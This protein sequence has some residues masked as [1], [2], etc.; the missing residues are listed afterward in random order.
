[1][2]KQKI[3]VV[4]DEALNV[5]IVYECLEDDYDLSSAEN[6]LVAWEM[7]QQEPQKF[8]LILLDRMMPVMNGIELLEKMK[9]SDEC[10]H[11]PVIL[12]SAKGSPKHIEE[13]MQAGAQFYLIKPF[14]EEA[15]TSLVSRALEAG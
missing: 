11:I 12:Q 5:E 14:E 4:D 13:G 10:L 2:D 15:L 6:G 1:M 7:L 9:Q 3:L 8:D